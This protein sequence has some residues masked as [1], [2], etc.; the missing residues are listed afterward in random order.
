MLLRS[1]LDRAYEDRLSGVIPD[2]PWTKSTQFQEELF[3]KGSENLEIGS[4]RQAMTAL[5]L[6]LAV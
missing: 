1:K 4:P 5:R 6:I 2:E 3:A